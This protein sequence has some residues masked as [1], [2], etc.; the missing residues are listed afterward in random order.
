MGQERADTFRTCTLPIT[1]LLIS[2]GKILKKKKKSEEG[3]NIKPN[4]KTK[5]TFPKCE[6]AKEQK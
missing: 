2:Q 4:L 1:I 6:T 5:P 3:S